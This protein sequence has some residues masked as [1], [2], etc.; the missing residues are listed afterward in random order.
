MEV[1]TTIK[2]CKETLLL[3]PDHVLTLRTH[4]NA[5]DKVQMWKRDDHDVV[6]TLQEAE[7]LTELALTDK[8]ALYFSILPSKSCHRS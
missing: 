4:S 1:A 5:V 3:S 7:T 6:I 8:T 2:S